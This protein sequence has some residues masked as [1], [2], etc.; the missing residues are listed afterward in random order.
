MFSVVDDTP[1]LS[2]NYPI[3]YLAVGWVVDIY[4]SICLSEW[5]V[6]GAT[7]FT[8]VKARVQIYRKMSRH[9]QLMLPNIYLH[10]KAIIFTLFR[11]S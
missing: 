8:T 11:R 6:G 7:G 5:G 10:E 1:A 2:Y 4:R 3:E 9:V